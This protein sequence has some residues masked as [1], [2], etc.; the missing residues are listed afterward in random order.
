MKRRVTDRGYVDGETVLATMTILL[1]A[2]FALVIVLV[3]MD[4]PEKT[5]SCES[6]AD[7]PIQSVPARCAE[8]FGVVGE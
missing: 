7:W 4:S 2:A 1:L 5:Q 3:A 8:H 6:F